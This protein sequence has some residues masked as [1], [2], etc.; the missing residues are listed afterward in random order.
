MKYAQGKKVESVVDIDKN[1]RLAGLRH[2]DVLQLL[3]LRRIKVHYGLVEQPRGRL[4]RQRQ[5]CSLK[6]L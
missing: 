5:I 6:M 2:L 3:R 4:V 1:E